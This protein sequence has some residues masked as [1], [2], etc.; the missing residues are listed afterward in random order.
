MNEYLV[1]LW[2]NAFN[3]LASGAA[4]DRLSKKEKDN[5]WDP[6]YQRPMTQQA[7]GIE[8]QLCRFI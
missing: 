8:Y 2:I 4:V 1:F 5:H 7:R 3:V 6:L